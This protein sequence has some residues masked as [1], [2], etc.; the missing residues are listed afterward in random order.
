V[1]RLSIESDHFIHSLYFGFFPL[2]RGHA[3]RFW[4][5]EHARFDLE[6]VGVPMIVNLT[7]LNSDKW[8]LGCG[9]EDARNT[10]VERYEVW[11]KDA[12]GVEWMYY[13]SFCSSGSSLS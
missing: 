1:P 6:F 5:D 9:K 8:Q 7:A 4:K 11:W 3:G 13:Q 10:I 12:K 2:F